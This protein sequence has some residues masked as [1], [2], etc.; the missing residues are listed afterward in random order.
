MLKIINLLKK[1]FSKVK[2]GKKPES[3]EKAEFPP[4]TKIGL[5]GHANVGK[6]VFFTVL[7]ET[8]RYDPEFKLDSRDT[9]TA[10]ELVKNF[11]DMTGLGLTVRD[12]RRMDKRVARTFPPPT[13]ETKY[14]S[15]V[16]VLNKR[17][18]MPF[19]SVDYRGEIASIHEQ[20]ELK[21]ELFKFISRSDCLLFFM[22]PNAIHSEVDCREQIT[23]FNDILQ[24]LS[25]G[26]NKGL[27]LPVGLVITKADQ[28]VGFEDESQATLIGR[29]CEYSKAKGYR[30]FVDQLLEQP[31]VKKRG[32]WRE[33]LKTIMNRLRTFFETLSVM[34][35][36]FQVFFIS[37]L[38]SPPLHEVGD[39]GAVVITPPRELKPIGIKEP[40]RWASQRIL[41]KKRLNVLSRITKWVLGLTLIWILFYSIPNI[42]NLVFWYPKIDAVET[43]IESRKGALAEIEDR[44]LEGFAKDYRDYTRRRWVHSFFG[45]GELKSFAQ[46]REIDLK[47]V[48]KPVQSTTKGTSEEL[49]ERDQIT[50]DDAVALALPNKKLE[51]IKKMIADSASSPE[52]LVVTAADSLR[53]FLQS[54]NSVNVT[55]KGGKDKLESMKSR[56]NRYLEKTECFSKRTSFDI[57]DV[58]VIPNGYILYVRSGGG[59]WGGIFPDEP[60]FRKIPWTK[61]DPVSYILVNEETYDTSDSV[62]LG[63]FGI[64]KNSVDTVQF[65]RV[66]RRL[67]ITKEG[68]N[69]KLPT[70][71]DL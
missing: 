26:G 47:N 22:E 71:Q 46:Q 42:M 68:F 6:T 27:S 63:S 69:C 33:E 12:G 11:E 55:S 25:D 37:A 60:E 39:K 50:T 36:D 51:E 29:T 23:S 54:L 57:T 19:T 10:S 38:G 18:R 40:F 21:E 67:I 62:Y 15:F 31:Q 58:R 17:T 24:R 52:F 34:N 43:A 61:D 30:Q 53:L 16:A 14:L 4:G 44:Q 65:P 48:P 32:R 1:L 41:L 66:G 70:A 2:T 64:L 45:M 56:V 49:A 13:S 5:F 8:T 7:F 35:L 3:K 59:R 28:L 9:K 20:P